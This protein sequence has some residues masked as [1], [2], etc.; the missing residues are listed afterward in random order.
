MSVLQIALAKS[1]TPRCARWSS[2]FRGAGRLSR[3]EVVKRLLYV[4]IAPGL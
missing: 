2:S 1:V 3:S 4:G